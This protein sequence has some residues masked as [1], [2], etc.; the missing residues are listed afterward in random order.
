MALWAVRQGAGLTFSVAAQSVTLHA[1]K[2]TGGCY[3]PVGCALPALALCRY[4]T[5]YYIYI[6]P[7]D[8]L[9][10]A[11]SCSANH[12][13]SLTVVLVA[14]HFAVVGSPDVKHQI[15]A[16]RACQY[17]RA[18]GVGVCAV[19]GGEEY[20]YTACCCHLCPACVSTI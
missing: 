3:G 17:V 18:N 6:K 11:P 10:S 5:V 15:R 12:T 16:V 9:R 19:G 13:P 4:D 20:R 7:F 14:W 2:Y 1:F 8:P